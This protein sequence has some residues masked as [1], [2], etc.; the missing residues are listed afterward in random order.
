M[1]LEAFPCQFP[2]SA[3][4]IAAGRRALRLSERAREG[5]AATWGRLVQ[6]GL[7]EMRTP[8]KQS[9]KSMPARGGSNGLQRHA[10]AAAALGKR[11]ATTNENVQ[12][13]FLR[14]RL[15]D[16]FLLVGPSLTKNPSRHSSHQNILA[17]TSNDTLFVSTKTFL[18]PMPDVS[19]FV[20]PRRTWDSR[21]SN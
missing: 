8:G 19:E 3:K 7:V 1:L 12:Q 10:A 13:L 17:R 4:D 11:I 14:A 9:E 18:F 20:F 21:L 16:Q 2:L 15:F 6:F 5:G